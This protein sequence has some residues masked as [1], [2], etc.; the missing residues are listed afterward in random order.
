MPSR[1]S[2]ANVFEIKVLCNRAEGHNLFYDE[3]NDETRNIEAFLLQTAVMEGV[4]TSLGICLLESREDLSALR[5]KRKGRYGYDS[6]INDLY[7]MGA[8]TTDEFKDLESFKNERNKYIH[9]LLSED[10]ESTN[11]KLSHSFNKN[12]ALVLNMVKKLE[13]ELENP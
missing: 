6:A 8:I 2:S 1:K 5:G 3:E 7:L 11:K 9:N 10:L 13:R 4:L 12:K